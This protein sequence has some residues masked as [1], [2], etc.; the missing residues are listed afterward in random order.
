[1]PQPNP[2]E[3][4]ERRLPESGLP[5]LQVIQLGT[6]PPHNSWPRILLVHGTMDRSTSFK[7]AARYLSDYEV[8]SY[9]RRGYGTSPFLESNGEPRKVSWQIHLADLAEIIHEKPTVVFGHSYGG[10]LTLLAAERRV[11]N[12]LGIITFEPPL[13]WWQGWSRWSAHSLDPTDEID[14]EWAKREARRFMIAQIGEEAWNRLPVKTKLARESEGVTMAS[15][16]SSMAH[17]FPVLDPSLISV[18]AIIAR[19]ENAPER[20]VKGTLYLAEN[21]PNSRLEV[22]PDTN[23]GVHLRR[24]EKV[25]ELIS[26]LIAVC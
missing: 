13:S 21:I 23:H 25:G 1:M 2:T 24:P 5:K 12:L 6:H 17:L 11:E 9:D 19:S 16:M 4:D 15:E 20:H 8:V 14:S 22:V 26:Q 3:S 18:P 7:K 10:T